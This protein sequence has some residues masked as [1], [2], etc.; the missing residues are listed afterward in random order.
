MDEKE[1]LG[2]C[3]ECLQ[4]KNLGYFSECDIQVRVT[5]A[6]MKVYSQKYDFFCE[7]PY[8]SSR[9]K[10]DIVLTEKGDYKKPVHWLEI[11]P[12]GDSSDWYYAKPSKFFNEAPFKEDIRKLYSILKN[13]QNADQHCWFLI[14]ASTE[15]ELILDNVENPI[16][17][18]RLT[19]SQMSKAISKWSKSAPMQPVPMISVNGIKYY[20]LLWKIK[21]YRDISFE[22]KDGRYDI[23]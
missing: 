3:S 21:D 18:K 14:V 22:P 12:A 6:L 23:S 13:N 20:L 2:L 1:F 8:P 11:K 19:L 15:N 17:K 16:Q 4:D 5:Q 7:Y 9:D 10:C